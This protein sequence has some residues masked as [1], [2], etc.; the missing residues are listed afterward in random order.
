MEKDFLFPN[1]IIKSE[2]NND[3]QIEVKFS[4]SESKNEKKDESSSKKEINYF[5][6]DYL[7]DYD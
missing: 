4:S 5:S 6:E 1:E 2:N 7:Q 3:L